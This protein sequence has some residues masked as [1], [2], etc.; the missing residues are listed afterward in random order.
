MLEIVKYIAKSGVH[1]SLAKRKR[2]KNQ[3]RIKFNNICASLVC[4]AS[5][6]RLVTQTFEKCDEKNTGITNIAL[7]LWAEA[8]RNL[9]SK[10]CAEKAGICRNWK[11]AAKSSHLEKLNHFRSEKNYFLPIPFWEKHAVSELFQL[12]L[13]M[14]YFKFKWTGN[15]F[16][17]KSRHLKD[18]CLHKRKKCC[19]K[20]VI[21]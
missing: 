15:N 16:W 9:R 6:S 11:R 1:S 12:Q 19:T 4:W 17:Q 14:I 20:K 8:W 21:V 18:V 2:K 5:F 3:K 7:E 13:K 10:R